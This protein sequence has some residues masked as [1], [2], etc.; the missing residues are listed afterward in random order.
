MKVLEELSA[1]VQYIASHILKETFAP[2]GEEFNVMSLRI[3]FKMIIFLTVYFISSTT[4]KKIKTGQGDI[5]NDA[6]NKEKG[7]K[8]ARN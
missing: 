2:Y 8:R 3:S 5:L 7:K 1:T 6:M 4:L